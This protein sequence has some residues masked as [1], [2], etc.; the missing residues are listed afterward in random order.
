MAQRTG[1][2]LAEWESTFVKAGLSATFTKIYVQTFSSEE[3]TRDSLHMLDHT[4][5]K[6][7][8]IKTMGD[9]LAILKLTEEP[10]IS[11]ACQMKPPTAK[12]PQ[13]SPVM[14][15]IQQLTP[16]NKPHIHLHTLSRPKSLE[17]YPDYCH[18][19]DQ[20]SKKDIALIQPNFQAA[21]GGR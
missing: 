17:L 5:L 18:I 6:E 21:G 4:M 1:Y 9:M 20:A 3:I 15:H 14:T 10:L 7:L 8:G 19:T 16:L 13:L 12:L 11:P 2:D